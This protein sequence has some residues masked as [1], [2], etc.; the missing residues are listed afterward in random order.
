MVRHFPPQTRTV[1]EAGSGSGKYSAAFALRGYDVT[2]LDCSPYILK[3]IAALAKRLRVQYGKIKLQTRRGN[4]NRLNIP[5]NT[6][7]AVVNDG[8]VEHWLDEKPRIN[9]IHEMVRVTKPGGIIG[10]IVPNGSHPFRRWWETHGYQE[11]T[12][13]PPMIYYTAAQLGREL[14]AA[15]AMLLETDG[16]HPWNTLG[17]WPR[18]IPLLVV[19]KVLSWIVPL[20]RSMRERWG[21]SLIAVGRKPTG[22]KSARA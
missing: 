2:A 22:R 5:S 10:I 12:G 15:G 6:Y 9:A 11:S 4:L 19:A 8:V 3:N 17:F 18:I 16:I 13:S 1:L 14:R 20:P 21:I 7:D